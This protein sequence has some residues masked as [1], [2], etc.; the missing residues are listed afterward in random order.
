MKNHK[1]CLC[2]LAALL[3]LLLMAGS[4]MASSGTFGAIYG[5][6]T[7]NLRAQGS[8]SSQWLGSCT[9]GTWVE[10]NGSQQN[11][12]F[13]LRFIC[14]DDFFNLIISLLVNTD[15]VNHFKTGIFTQWSEF[16]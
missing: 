13:N 2:A 7:L 9:R 4:A 8:S 1:L 6:D 3:L 11:I 16:Y 12:S 5:T 14:F 15:M 10:I